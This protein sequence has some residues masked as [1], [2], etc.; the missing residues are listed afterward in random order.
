MGYV[1][2]LY[3]A[4]VGADTR[5]FLLC[6]DSEAAGAGGFAEGFIKLSMYL[7][8]GGGV[9]AIT[10]NRSPTDD[11]FSNSKFLHVALLHFSFKTILDGVGFCIGLCC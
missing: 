1:G 2:L 4:L 5:G 7:F 11:E 3:L 10:D 6:A 8:K 9:K